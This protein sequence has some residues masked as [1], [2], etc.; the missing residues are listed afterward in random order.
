MATKKKKTVKTMDVV[1]PRKNSKKSKKSANPS[2]PSASTV[3]DI[4]VNDSPEPTPIADID[5]NETEIYSGDSPETSLIQAD[6]GTIEITTTPISSDEYDGLDETLNEGFP[7][8]EEDIFEEEVYEEPAKKPM[9]TKQEPE[10]TMKAEVKKSPKKSP[11]QDIATPKK[12]FFKSPLKIISG[13]IVLAAS[14]SLGILIFNISRSDFLPAK[15]FYPLVGAIIVLMLVFLRFTFR[16]KTKVPAHIVIDLF[17]LVFLVASIFGNL[18]LGDTITFLD[19]NLNGT[20]YQTI[21]YN[22]LTSADS[23]YSTA[24]DLAGATISAPPDFVLSEDELITE[25]QNQ[26]GAKLVFDEN[27]E[28]VTNLPITTP[29]SLVMLGESIY[30]SIVESGTDYSSKTK[31]IATVKINKRIEKESDDGDLASKPFLIFLSG[32]DTREDGMPYTSLSDVNMAIAVN[33]KTAQ[34]LLVTVPRDYYIQIPG[35]TVLKDKLTHA[36]ALGGVGLSEATVAELLDVKFNDYIRVNFNFLVGLVDAVGGINLY[37]DDRDPF[38]CWTDK[39]CYFTPG[40]NYVYGRCALAFA[41]ERRHYLN[42]DIQRAANQQQVIEKVF[43]KLSTSTLLAKYSEI[44]DSLNGT[45]ETSLTSSDISS[46]VRYQLDN[47]PHWKIH[48]YTLNGTLGKDY[49][50]SYPL[51][52]NDVIYPDAST[53]A[54]AK[55]LIQEVLNGK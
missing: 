5:I 22:V 32:I 17:S 7:E 6:T 12:S 37:S 1:A 31:I 34:I 45:F 51:E 13:L 25:V 41:R 24:S 35:T 33:P 21:T 18:K 49:T 48:S 29:D 28:A 10:V 19:K 27:I 3:I 54:K 47:F 8:L 46:L 39:G 50:Y 4:E 23:K 2:S 55:E 42:G 36:G 53:V 16:R 38:T 26:L 52:A 11:E 40:D 15:Y 43:D 44:L 14:V 9:S 20:A 30:N